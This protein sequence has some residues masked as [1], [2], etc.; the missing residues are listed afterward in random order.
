[1]DGIINDRIDKFFDE[2]EY[3]LEVRMAYEYLSDLNQKIYLY[4]VNI[5][6]GNVDDLYHEA[7]ANEIVLE[8]P[9]ELYASVEILDPVNKAYNDD[10]TLRINEL[11]NMLAHVLIPELKFKSCNP[12]Y[13]DYLV[14]M[15]DD[16]LN[17]PFPLVFQVA[18]D[19]N[20]NYE[21]IR[22]WGGYK[23]HFKTLIGTPVDK[24]ELKIEF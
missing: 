12:K 15:V 6:D 11:G 9:I 24:N 8:A 18:N 10:N 22:S 19:G 16:G 13:G 4:A 2:N 1:M 3:D 23:S 14:Y 17:A 7:L 5:D 21:N 20:R